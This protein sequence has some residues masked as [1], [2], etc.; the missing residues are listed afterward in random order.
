MTTLTV[1]HSVKPYPG[2]TDPMLCWE[3]IDG[4]QVIA[5]LWVRPD[6]LTI[7]NVWVHEDRR[8]EGHATHLYRAATATHAVLHDVPWHRTD[9]GNAWA[10][11]VGG[12][13]AETCNCCQHLFED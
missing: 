3:T 2:E 10:E 4:D 8:G 7:A 9:E 1:T 12:D 13:T 5:E 6:A 11:Q